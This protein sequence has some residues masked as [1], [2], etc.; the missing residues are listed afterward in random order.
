MVWNHSIDTILVKPIK[1]TGLNE[2]IMI[3][4][5]LDGEKKI[6][7]ILFFKGFVPHFWIYNI[8][9]CLNKR[10]IFYERSISI[11]TTLT[12]NDSENRV[13]NVRL[14]EYCYIYYIDDK[15]NWLWA[16]FFSIILSQSCFIQM[17][18]L[19]KR[20]LLLRHKKCYF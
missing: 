18:L 9:V 20:F 17:D 4:S 3:F 6:F 10:N 7:K 14:T 13:L 15:T 5:V 19:K 2:N 12:R 8:F 16:P 11:K 1:P